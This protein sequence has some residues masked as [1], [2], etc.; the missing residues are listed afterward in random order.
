MYYKYYAPT[1]FRL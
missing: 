1:E